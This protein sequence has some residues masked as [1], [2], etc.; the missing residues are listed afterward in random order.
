M[1]HSINLP[2]KINTFNET[3]TVKSNEKPEILNSLTKYVQSYIERNIFELGLNNNDTKKND[4][5]AECKIACKLA[6]KVIQE[7]KNHN[8]AVCFTNREYYGKLQSKEAIGLYHILVGE[9]NQ[10][11]EIAANL[12][13]LCN[14]SNTIITNRKLSFW[15]TN[16]TSHAEKFRKFIDD[17]KIFAYKPE[18]RV[19]KSYDLNEQSLNNFN[20]E[21]TI[22]TQNFSA[23]RAHFTG[24]VNFAA[25][26]FEGKTDFAGCRFTPGVN[27]TVNFSHAVF[28]HHV[29]LTKTSFLG[30]DSRRHSYI[31]KIIFRGATFK[32]G[33]DLTHYFAGGR[34]KGNEI[35][36]TGVQV[37]EGKYITFPR[38]PEEPGRKNLNIGTLVNCTIRL[39][40]DVLK[41]TQGLY[42]AITYPSKIRS[43]PGNFQ[44]T[45]I[46]LDGKLIDFNKL[47]S[48]MKEE[49]LPEDE[50]LF[51][52]L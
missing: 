5:I 41:H 31:P 32:E 51:Y 45:E 39:N 26:K 36:L 46:F 3:T 17:P 13:V 33:I 24:N 22:F 6:V 44:A 23:V 48:I 12:D 52:K 50:F 2:S 29:D 43:E 37:P 1:I 18:T 35:D 9:S 42:H 19:E 28:D 49:G 4:F 20:A 21:S 7:A 15:G 38:F 27:G 10:D 16:Y 14:H 11:K 30:E 34:Y 25:C 40:R 8:G 47:E